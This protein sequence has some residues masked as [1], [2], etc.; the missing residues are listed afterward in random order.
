D[1][2]H[3]TLLLVL[4]EVN[5]QRHRCQQSLSRLIC[6]RAPIR[7]VPPEILAEI[8]HFSCR[9]YENTSIT[10]VQAAPLLLGQVCSLWR[11]VSQ[12]TPRLW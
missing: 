9:T 4:S 8:F 10:D 12:N 2:T 6:V 1:A 7:R 5:S 3:L 11:A